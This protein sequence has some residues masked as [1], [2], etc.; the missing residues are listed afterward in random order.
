W[1]QHL[2]PDVEKNKKKPWSQTEIDKLIAGHE[3]NGP[4]WIKIINDFELSG[5]SSLQVRN[6]FYSM[7]KEWKRIKD[8]M[9]IGRLLNTTQTLSYK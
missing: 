4:D 3:K 1:T 8:Q 5:R 2:N 9:S 6:K 7:R